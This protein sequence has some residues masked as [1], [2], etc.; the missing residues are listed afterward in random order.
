M[1]IIQ[2][3]LAAATTHRH[4]GTRCAVNLMN[5]INDKRCVGVF[6]FVHDFTPPAKVF[7]SKIGVSLRVCAPPSP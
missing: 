7:L 3:K 2:R 5:T 4:L 1:D 6:N